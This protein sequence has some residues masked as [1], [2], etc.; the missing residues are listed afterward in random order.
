MK[1]AMII[2]AAGNSRR[3]GGNKLLYEIDGRPMYKHIFGQISKAK[4]E[5]ETENKIVCSIAVVTQYETIAETARGNGVQVLYNL[6]P[7]RGIS[8]SVQI[9]LKAHLDADAALFTVSDQ[10]WLT[11]ETIIGLVKTFLD[12]KRGIACV[13]YQEKLGNPCI[14]KKKYYEELLALEGDKGGKKIIMKHLEDTQIY[15]VKEE[16]E[17]KD[18]DYCQNNRYY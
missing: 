12:S 1:I 17:L 4:S 13:S 8:L 18:I 5:I 10:P 7:D 11:S 6:H 3:F 2:L 15:E 9:G 14:F 16:R